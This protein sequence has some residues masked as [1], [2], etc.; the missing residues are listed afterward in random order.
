MEPETRIRG[1]RQA[2]RL[3]SD[4]ILLLRRLAASPP[5]HPEVGIML[6]QET[7]SFRVGGTWRDSHRA[8]CGVSAPC[9][10]A[11]DVSAWSEFFA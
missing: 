4:T 2:G 11:N 5:P 9:H 8:P 6:R 7:R 3:I 1:D 10:G